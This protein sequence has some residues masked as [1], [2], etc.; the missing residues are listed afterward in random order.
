MKWFT[1]HVSRGV[2]WVKRP[3]IPTSAEFK[4]NLVDILYRSVRWGM[5]S[6]PTG[7]RSMVGALLVVGGFFGFL[8]ILGY[9]MIPMGAA[10][11]ALD[12]PSVGRRLV[13]W[14]ARK[15]RQHQRQE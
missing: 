4:R 12:I 14:V 7:V 2:A 10:L 3:Q 6:V 1:D 15:Q 8:P 13:I 5:R 11:I 9:W